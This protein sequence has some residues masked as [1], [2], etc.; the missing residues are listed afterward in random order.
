MARH[1]N[2]VAVLIKRKTYVVES[3]HHG[4]AWKIAFADFAMAMM[5]FFLL[6]WLINATTE[7]QRKGIADYFDPTVMIG[8]TASGGDGLLG[9]QSILNDKTLTQT[10]TGQFAGFAVK[11]DRAE[12][13]YVP[14]E[15]VQ[16][17]GLQQLQSVLAGKG[18][19][20]QTMERLLSHVV[21]QVSDEGLV[22]DV[23]D[24]DDSPLFEE[25]SSLPTQT[26][27]EI[28][29]LLADVMSLTANNIAVAGFVRSY[30]VV[31][32]KTPSWDLSAE[33]AQAMRRLLEAAGL[34]QARIARISGHADRKP[35]VANPIAVRNNRIEVILLRQDR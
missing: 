7:E 21:T 19:E 25:D 33:R 4:G 20:S 34:G 13:E 26:L 12:A 17:A 2:A 35:A 30:P 16:G 1:A 31:L 9:G 29:A 5:A 27:I 28:S 18:G 11:F 8:G 10:G 14:N 6:M 22:I 24:T 15:T 3:G 32:I 23:F